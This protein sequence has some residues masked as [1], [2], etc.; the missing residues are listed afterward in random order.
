MCLDTD[1]FANVSHF[2][3]G[4]LHGCVG[5]WVASKKAQF[6]FGWFIDFSSGLLGAQVLVVGLVCLKLLVGGDGFFLRLSRSLTLDTSMYVWLGRV[7]AAS[8]LDGSEGWLSI[9]AN[10]SHFNPGHLN[11]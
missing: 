9:F 3:P 8:K 10:V 7:V 5:G 1:V 2:N 6:S 4:H 11:V